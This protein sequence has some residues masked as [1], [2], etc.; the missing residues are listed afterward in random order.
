MQY[1]EDKRLL[2]IVEEKRNWTPGQQLCLGKYSDPTASW[3]SVSTRRKDQLL[4]GFLNL[5]FIYVFSVRV[6]VRICVN[7]TM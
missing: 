2:V 1:T 5:I 7:A 4:F 6:R 3:N